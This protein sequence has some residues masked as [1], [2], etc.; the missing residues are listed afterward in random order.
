[1]CSGER[2]AYAYLEKE[3]PSTI[4]DMATGTGDFALKQLEW[5]SMH[6]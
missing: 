6:M 5:G 1:M 2:N 3:N 4:I